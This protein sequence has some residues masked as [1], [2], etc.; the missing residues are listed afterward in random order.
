MAEEQ[1]KPKGTFVRKLIVFGSIALVSAGA[2]L[3]VFFYVVAPIFREPAEVPSAPV[4]GDK[5]PLTTAIL[6]FKSMRA[7]VLADS[8]GNSTS[9]LLQYSVAVVCANEPTS[10]L[11]Q[12][13]LQMFQAILVKL[14]DSRTKSELTD[15]VAKDSLLRQAKSE[16][17]VLLKRL[18]EVEDPSIEVLDVMYTEYTVLE[19]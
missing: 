13:K 5:L 11:L 6:D 3:A 14:H 1:A 8:A 17:N 4:A 7:T 2:A 18:Q 12:S 15:S 10:L 16:I 19:L 9:A